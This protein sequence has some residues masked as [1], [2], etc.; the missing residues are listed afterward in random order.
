VF[1]HVTLTVSEVP[2]AVR[3]YTQ[4]LGPLGLRGRYG[5]TYFAVFAL[6]GNDVEAV[7]HEQ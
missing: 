1:A 6:D 5:P 7:T 2:C 4:V 3:F